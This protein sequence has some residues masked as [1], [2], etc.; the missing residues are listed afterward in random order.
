MYIFMEEIWCKQTENGVIQQNKNSVHTRQ[1]L[2][3]NRYLG[4]ERTV[5]RNKLYP[6]Q[7]TYITSIKYQV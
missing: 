1:R 2:N 4:G 5:I 7:I 3:T 6:H